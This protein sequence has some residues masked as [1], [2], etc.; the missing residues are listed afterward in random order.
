MPPWREKLGVNLLDNIIKVR[1]LCSGTSDLLVRQ[2]EVCGIPVALLMCEG[3]FSLA[4]TTE[5]IIEPLT[6]LKLEKAKPEDLLSWMRHKDDSLGDTSGVL[7]LR[8]VVPVYYVR[9]CSHPSGRE[10]C[11]H[12][13]GAPGFPVPLHLGTVLR[14]QCPRLPEGFVESLRVNMSMVRRRMKTQSSNWNFP[15]WGEKSKTDI[16][17]VYPHRYGIFRAFKKR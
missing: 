15:L 11:W 7:Y 8:G 9:L 5:L 17:L 10:K 16:C 3:M 6:H 4:N 13:F 12:G 1:E 14:N 2:M